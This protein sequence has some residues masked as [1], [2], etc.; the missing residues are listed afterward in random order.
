MAKVSIVNDKATFEVPDGSRLM[1]YAK[2]SSNMLFGCEAGQ[3]GVCICNI[4]Q[5]RENLNLRTAVE[6][7]TLVRMDAYPSQRLAC[8]IV[9]K[10]GEVV[11]EY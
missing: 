11:I 2:S 10:K 4:V 6:E 7:Q 9:V 1:D 8:Q 5:G 3:C